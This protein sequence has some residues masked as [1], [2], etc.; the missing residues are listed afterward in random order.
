MSKYSSGVIKCSGSLR[1]SRRSPRNGNA[2]REEKNITLKYNNVISAEYGGTMSRIHSSRKGRAGSRKPQ[3]TKNPEWVTLP[4]SEIENLVVKM[5]KEGVSTALIGLRLRDQ[6]GV[7]NIRLATGKSVLQILTANGVKF[8][9][10]ED[11]GNLI[12][13]SVSVQAHLKANKRDTENRRGHHLIDSKIKR[14]TKY[15]KRMEMLPENWI[16]ASTMETKGE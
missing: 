1:F 7:P 10:P 5:G 8:D 9:V 4:A 2:V 12:K 6:Y 3:V 16:P 11:L 13:R 14:L 15:Y